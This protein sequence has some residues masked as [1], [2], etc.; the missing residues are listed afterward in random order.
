MSDQLNKGDTVSWNWGQ[1]HP[2]G[3]VVGVHEEKTTIKSKNGNDASRN[4][5]HVAGGQITKNG[6]P[7]NPAV[8]IKQSNG[9]A[10][11]KKASELNE[12]VE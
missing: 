4:L 11:V 2:K 6:E 7:G 1:G 9:N 10:V 12:V 3:E 5:M 8:E